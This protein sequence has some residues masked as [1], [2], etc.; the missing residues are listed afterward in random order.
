MLLPV[1]IPKPL[2]MVIGFVVGLMVDLFYDSP[3]VHAAAGVFSGYVRG[4]ILNY[5]EP[6]E[7]FN[8]ND[9][10]TLYRFGYGWFMTYLSIFLA[11]H[12]LFYF[13]VEAFSFVFF[14]EIMMNTIFSFLASFVIIM[15]MI[16]IFKP[17][18]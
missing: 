7:G 10:P 4:Y 2:V 14:F 16:I 5:L 18:V 1:K 13:S 17:K 15:L 9:S 3:G 8:T 12:L 6:Y 11:L